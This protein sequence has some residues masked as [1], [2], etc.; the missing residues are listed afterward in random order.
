MGVL[1][2][3]GHGEEKTHILLVIKRSV[4]MLS[5]RLSS[6]FIGILYSFVRVRLLKSP[7]Q[8]LPITA[9]ICI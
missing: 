1:Q 3:V 4:K 5:S 2:S 6:T 8:I 7:S 9:K